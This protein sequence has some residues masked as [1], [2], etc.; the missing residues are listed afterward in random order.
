[1]IR[2]TELPFEKF[3]GRTIAATAEGVRLFVGRQVF[4]PAAKQTAHSWHGDLISR[5]SAR[6]NPFAVEKRRDEPRG[7]SWGVEFFLGKP[8]GS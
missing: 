5:Y 8:G 7:E 6:Q 2:K 4:N 1:M 3:V